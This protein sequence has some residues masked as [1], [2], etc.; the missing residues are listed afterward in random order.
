MYNNFEEFSNLLNGYLGSQDRSAAW[1]AQ[2]LN[3]HPGTVGRW[4]SG[5]Y[6]PKSPELIIRICD[7]LGIYS[8]EK[9]EELFTATGY[10]YQEVI[11]DASSEKPEEYGS[12]NFI[13][14]T[15][16]MA[17]VLSPA[18][19]PQGILGRDDEIAEVM[20]L[21]EFN[22]TNARD[23]AP[24]ALQGMGGIGK[25]T[26][27]VALARHKL[28]SKQYPDGVLWTALGP[29][30]T[31]R[32]L[33]NGWGR[34]LGLDLAPEL[35]ESTCRN[36]LQ[37]ALYNRR[38]L[39]IVDDVWETAHGQYFMVAGPQCRTLVTTRESPV[40]HA[41]ATRERSKRVDVLH[42][43][44]ALELLGHLAPEAVNR[45]S[46][47]ARKLCVRL[48]C[49][50][51]ALTL[52]G[53]LLANEADVPSRM[54]RVLDELIER[55]Q[56]RLKLLQGE[57][58]LGIDEDSPVSLQ[59]ILGMSVER[60]DK[61]NQER[62][63]MLSVFGAEPLIWTPDAVAYVWECEI[64]EA[65]KTISEFIQRGLVVY[66]PE[67]QGYWMHMLLADY[68]SEMREERGL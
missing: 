12:V 30:P 47:S 7:L 38:M 60:L 58:R 2:K 27:A 22:N 68:A 61:T 4:L 49:L 59:A 56:A 53:R 21:L 42:E 18:P 8:R 51:L 31:I 65:E 32:N 5:E 1:L 25:T 11:S 44:I 67:Q 52:A 43:D 40:A 20:S 19:P 10:A 24:V 63:A 57:G 9:K 3:V 26:L 16:D 13:E 54:Q 23:V 64:R 45:D 62:F 15:E 46:D 29:K 50:P 6:R 36:A 14:R 34:Q 48:E 66:R 33:L 39:L 41:L 35:N 17:G 37:A 28:I 55:R